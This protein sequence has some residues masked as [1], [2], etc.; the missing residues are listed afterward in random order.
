MPAE[1]I[2]W[3]QE[4][5]SSIRFGDKRLDMRFKRMAKQLAER[6]S[7]PINQAC[8]HWA[9]TKAAYRFFANDKVTPQ[10]IRSVHREK[11][12]ERI[13]QYPV[14]LGIQDTSFLNYTEHPE[15]R[16]LGHIGTN[17]RQHSQGLLM[18]SV[19]AVSPEGLPLG[20][21]HRNHSVVP[22]FY[23]QVCARPNN[24]QSSATSA[25]LCQPLQRVTIPGSPSDFLSRK[26]PSLPIR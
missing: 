25:S 11:T 15:T 23:P 7:A 9:D 24:S 19:Y 22:F 5:F 26:P 1:S 14:V 4:E 3:C 21:L 8:E 12:L 18:H 10:E 17:Q 16:G 6:P 13:D 2:N 20:L